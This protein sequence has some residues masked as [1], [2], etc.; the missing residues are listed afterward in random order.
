MKQKINMYFYIF[1]LCSIL[2]K[3]GS[4]K[5]AYSKVMFKIYIIAS[6]YKYLKNNK[7]INPIKAGGVWI[8]V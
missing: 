6:R 8:Y 5:D 3:G 4:S 7:Y 1:L 2:R